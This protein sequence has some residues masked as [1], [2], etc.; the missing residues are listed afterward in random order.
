MVYCTTISSTSVCFDICRHM[1]FKKRSYSV[2]LFVLLR[3]LESMYITFNKMT[4]IIA[5]HK[6]YYCP[7]KS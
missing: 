2:D 7:I 5:H 1:S 4:V 6:K 3:L